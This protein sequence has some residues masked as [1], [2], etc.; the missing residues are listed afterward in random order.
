MAICLIYS[1][2]EEQANELITLEISG[3]IEQFTFSLYESESPVYTN[4]FEVNG[5]ATILIKPGRY[6]YQAC[7]F[8][9]YSTKNLTIKE[10]EVI[11][12]TFLY[13]ECPPE[14]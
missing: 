10:S 6:F 9:R 11:F 5:K 13:G 2:S 1:C 12:I 14:F 7:A 8:G 4:R 3:E